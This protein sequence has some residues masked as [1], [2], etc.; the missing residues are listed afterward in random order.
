MLFAAMTGLGVAVV[1][2][3]RSAV[4][5][6]PTVVWTVAELFERFGSLVPAVAL[7]TSVITLPIAT[8][9]FKATP[10][11]NVVEAAE[12]KSGLAHEIVPVPP[13]EGA[14]QVQPEPPGKVKD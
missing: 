11:V 4:L 2:M 8:P 6:K 3:E 14:T 9:V 5:A 10:T 13:T 12:E 7:T 1:V